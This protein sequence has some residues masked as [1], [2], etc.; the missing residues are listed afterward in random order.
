MLTI[1]LLLAAKNSWLKWVA[2]LFVVFSAFVDQ[3]YL[4]I[5]KSN[6]GFHDLALLYNDMGFGLGPGIL[7]TYQ[8]SLEKALVRTGVGAL[9]LAL[10][11]RSQTIKVKNSVAATGLLLSIGIAY[12]FLWY[13]IGGR[14]AVPSAVRLPALTAYLIPNSLYEGD[15]SQVQVLPD[16]KSDFDHIIWV[17]DE[18]IRG[19]HLQINNPKYKTTPL[20]NK[21]QDQ[22]ISLVSAPLELFAQITRTSC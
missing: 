22:F 6:F 11:V 8:S 4:G 1:G 21:K 10:L 18:S 3:L 15:R 2:F 5:S 14:Q 12:Y 7:E 20:L 16:A 9:C 17:V 19:D 13:S